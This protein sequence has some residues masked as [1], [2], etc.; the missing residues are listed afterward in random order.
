MKEIKSSNLQ[1]RPRGRQRDP[2]EIREEILRPCP[3]LGYDRDQLALYLMSRGAYKI[4]EAQFRRI[5]WLNPYEPKFKAHLAICL[6]NTKRYAEA[7]EWIT[8]SLEK[9]PQED[10]WL[11]LLKMIEEKLAGA[12]L[13]SIHP[14]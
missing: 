2:N 11:R 12:Q 1:G 8:R 5:I 10:E 14:E 4:A 7:R 9:K 3:Y 13:E 6:F